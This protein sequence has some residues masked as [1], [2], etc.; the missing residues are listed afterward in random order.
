MTLSA[1]VSLDSNL[2][3]R[4]EIRFNCSALAFYWDDSIIKHIM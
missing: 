2:N 1:I 3:D 4:L